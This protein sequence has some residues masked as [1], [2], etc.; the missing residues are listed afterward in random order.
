MAVPALLLLQIQRREEKGEGRTLRD[1][2]SGKHPPTAAVWLSKPSLLRVPP[3]LREP[4]PGHR[5]LGWAGLPLSRG[6]WA[7]GC[8]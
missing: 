4:R 7:A 6:V 1:L 5:R 2:I 3:Q 8:S